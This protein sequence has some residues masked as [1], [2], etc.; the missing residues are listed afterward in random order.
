M[1]VYVSPVHVLTLAGLD[2]ALH[3]RDCGI[4]SQLERMGPICSR[5]TRLCSMHS[6]SC[7]MDSTKL[8]HV[9]LGQ[10]DKLRA[11]RMG[12]MTTLG[13]AGSQASATELGCPTCPHEELHDVWMSLSNGV[14]GAVLRTVSNARARRLARRLLILACPKTARGQFL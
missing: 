1:S 2:G 4:C 14:T 11:L 13:N 7:L 5:H 3:I 9:P 10:C 12:S 6:F 8:V